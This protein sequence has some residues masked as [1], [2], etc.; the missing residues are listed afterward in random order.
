[1]STTF[2]E[3]AIRLLDG[4][5]LTH[6]A[7]DVGL[8]PEGTRPWIDDRPFVGPEFWAPHLQLRQACAAFRRLRARGWSTACTWFADDRQYGEAWA[9][10]STRSYSARWPC[11]VPT[12][13][14]ALLLVSVLVVHHVQRMA[15]GGETMQP[16]V[17]QLSP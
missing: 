17:E 12:E 1:M 7:F 9:S 6:L 4:P 10:C 16:I 8:A 11:D 13:A 3:E 2:T 5:A 14:L 15:P